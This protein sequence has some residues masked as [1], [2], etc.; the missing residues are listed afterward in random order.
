[1]K[2]RE[3]K[4]TSK[5]AHE[6]VKPLKEA[7]WQKIL[8]GLDDLKVGGTFAEIATAAKLK[9]EQVWKRLSEMQADGKIYDTGITRVL[10]SGRKGIVWQSVEIKVKQSATPISLP[11]PLS[12]SK[13]FN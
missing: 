11:K 2:K 7:Y 1:M 8:E 4:P 5:A 6:S 3:H 10:P 12:Q 13:M 9:P